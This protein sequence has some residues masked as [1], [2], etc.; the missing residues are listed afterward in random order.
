MIAAGRRQ[1]KKSRR[2][3][4]LLTRLL[5]T[6]ALKKSKPPFLCFPYKR[7]T[8][9]KIAAVSWRYRRVPFLAT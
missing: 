6:A 2:A 8:T 9:Y 3:A 4:A 1:K 5:E 7:M